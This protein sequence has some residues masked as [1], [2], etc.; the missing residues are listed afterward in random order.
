MK[1]NNKKVIMR[2]K[3]GKPN[4]EKAI[5]IFRIIYYSILLGLVLYVV[6]YFIMKSMIIKAEGFVS[7][8]MVKIESPYNGIVKD[9]NITQNIKKGQFLC[10]IQER[11]KNNGVIKSVSNNTQIDNLLIKIDTLKVKYKAKQNE[12][13]LLKKEYEKISPYNSL[14]LY[15]PKSTIIQ[16]L[17]N[18]IK[19]AQI[20]LDILKVELKDYKKLYNK[21]KHNHKITVIPPIFRYIN[22]PIYSPTKGELFKS[23][24]KND[25]PVKMGELLFKIQTYKNLK[26]IGFF[27]QKYLNDIAIGDKIKIIIGDSEYYGKINYISPVSSNLKLKTLQKLKVIII[28]IEGEEEFWRKCNLLRVK[29][30]KY[31]W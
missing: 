22:H 28:P 20:E 18:K 19:Q 9:L 8:D 29:L 27:S 6:Y 31:K 5:D 1:L 25:T 2:A 4:P 16:T 23:I 13:A 21:L 15:S 11:I 7:F 10:N 3:E 14:G 26:I 30:R 24:D 12:L 17:K